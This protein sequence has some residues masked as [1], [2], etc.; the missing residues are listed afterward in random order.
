M[1]GQALSSSLLVGPWRR[2]FGRGGPLRPAPLRGTLSGLPERAGLAP[3]LISICSLSCPSL[4]PAQPRESQPPTCRSA[5]VT[6]VESRGVG[7]RGRRPQAPGPGP[8]GPEQ[9]GWEASMPASRP[10]GKGR[11]SLKSYLLC[12]WASRGS[13]MGWLLVDNDILCP[14]Q[15][16]EE[17]DWT[18][19]EKGGWGTRK[20]ARLGRICI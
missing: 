16:R 1:T 3:K 18:E 2:E 7:P 20:K 13:R 17:A 6:P 11:D 8:E 10:A 14:E 19:R 4:R 12:P 5:L 15:P 9:P